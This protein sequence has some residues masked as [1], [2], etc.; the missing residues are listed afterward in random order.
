MFSVAGGKVTLEGLRLQ[1][2]PPK[3]KNP[4]PWRAVTVKSGALR[5]LNCT[6]SETNKQGTTGVIVEAPGQTVIRNCLFVGGAAAVELIANGK[7][8]LVFDN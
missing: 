8:E 6:I 3:Y 4:V 1:L 7:Q 2:D 5:L